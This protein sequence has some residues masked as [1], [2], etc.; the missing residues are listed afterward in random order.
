VKIFLSSG[1]NIKPSKKSVTGGKKILLYVFFN[2]K[3]GAD[4]LRVRKREMLFT[5]QDL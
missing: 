5:V 1:L 3:D 4:I 2:P